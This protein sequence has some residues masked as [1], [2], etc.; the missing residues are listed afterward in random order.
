MNLKVLSPHDHG[1]DPAP[2]DTVMLG[3]GLL[4]CK[5]FRVAG[6]TLKMFGGSGSA[7]YNLPWGCLVDPIYLYVDVYLIERTWPM[8][9]NL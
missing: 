5:S 2:D 1:H 4:D 6:L 8:V 3:E 9:N 7:C